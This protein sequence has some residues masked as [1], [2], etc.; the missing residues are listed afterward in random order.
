MTAAP[1]GNVCD[2]RCDASGICNRGCVA[3]LRGVE[4][5]RFCGDMIAESECE[6]EDWHC[7]TCRDD[8]QCRICNGAPS[9]G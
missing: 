7:G 4:E 2:G 1:W 5:C 8:G 6:S 3:D 9:R